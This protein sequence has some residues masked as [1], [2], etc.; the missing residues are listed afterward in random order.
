MTVAQAT[1]QLNT[2]LVGCSDTALAALDADY[3]SR[4][5][6]TQAR[7]RNWRIWRLRGLYANSYPM[8]GEHLAAY[9]AAID[10]LL[11]EMGAEPEGARQIRIKAEHDRYE[12]F[13]AQVVGDCEDK[14]KQ[15]ESK[16]QGEWV[17]HMHKH[18]RKVLV[19]AIPNGTHI[20]SFAGRARIKAEGLYTGFP[21]TGAHWDGGYAY[22]EWKD[23]KGDPKP[24]QIECLNRLETEMSNVANVAADELRL[25][26]ERVERLSEE[27]AGISEDITDVFKEAKG[28]GF[29]T[30]AMKTIV[31]M[32]KKDKGKV[33]EEMT[34]LETYLSALGMQYAML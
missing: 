16:R 12:A 17:N 9:Q 4:C 14:G 6:K 34:V 11:A 8:M 32:R 10:A 2:L 3:L 21:D 24:A 15:S 22:L 25:L 31:Q 28:R 19:F 33:Q 20:P 13:R 29:D 27:R 5:Y 1:T 7:N 26:I 18:A 23:S 30:K